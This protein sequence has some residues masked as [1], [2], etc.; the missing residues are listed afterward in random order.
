M[1]SPTNLS[2][3]SMSPSSLLAS[4]PSLVSPSRPATD[5]R[6]IATTA[7]LWQEKARGALELTPASKELSNQ[8]YLVGLM[9]GYREQEK[10]VEVRKA[11][12]AARA[13]AL[14]PPVALSSTRMLTFSLPQGQSSP[15]ETS[16]QLPTSLPSQVPSLTEGPFPMH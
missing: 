14:P 11:S 7:A 8:L 4:P 13:I 5:P 12:Q 15:N 10:A 3:A 6:L 1:Y 16:V 9:S 2:Q